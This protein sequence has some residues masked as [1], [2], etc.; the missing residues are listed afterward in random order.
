MTSK[1]FEHVGYEIT[2]ET[3]KVGG[4]YRWS[5]DIGGGLGSG[6]CKDRPLPSEGLVLSEGIS[7][8]KRHAERLKLRPNAQETGG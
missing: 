1:T 4:G 3:F 7:E 2:V 6:D 8:A 5:Y